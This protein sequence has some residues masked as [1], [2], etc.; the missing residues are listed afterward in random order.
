MRFSSSELKVRR[1]LPTY[2]LK[3]YKLY[4]KHKHTYRTRTH[5]QACGVKAGRF[6]TRKLKLTSFCS[7]NNFSRLHKLLFWIHMV[8]VLMKAVWYSWNIYT[9]KFTFW[10]LWKG[11]TMMWYA[12]GKPVYFLSLVFCLFFL[13]FSVACVHFIDTLSFNSYLGVLHPW[14]NCFYCVA[15]KQEERCIH[16]A[17]LTA[18]SLLCSVYGFLLTA[19]PHATA[20]SRNLHCD[21]PHSNISKIHVADYCHFSYNDAVWNFPQLLL[22]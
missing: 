10:S 11:N 6:A 15:G 3:C 2:T 4:N 21:S 9:S 7:W 13:T 18:I 1:S 16:P 14:M 22:P 19:W 5:K 17:H 8:R 12:N 20:A